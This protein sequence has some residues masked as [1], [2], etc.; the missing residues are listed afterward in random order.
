MM[1]GR[2]DDVLARNEAPVAAVV[3]IVA[4]VAHGEDV[5][6]RH[7]QFAVDDVLLDHLGGAR[8]Q[9]HGV[10]AGGEVVAVRVRE[11]LV[12]GPCRAR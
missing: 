12:S 6:R 5:A 11:L 4:V 3:G 9:R 8:A 10:G 2:A 7:D 1:S